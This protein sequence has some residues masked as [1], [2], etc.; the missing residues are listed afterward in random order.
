MRGE[1]GRPRHARSSSATV[2]WMP[3][4]PSTRPHELARALPHPRRRLLLDRRVRARAGAVRLRRRDRRARAE[5]RRVRAPRC[6]AWRA[7]PRGDGP[8]RGG[9]RGREAAIATARRLGRQDNVVLE[10]L[11][12]CRCARSS[13][14]EEARGR[15]EIVVDRLGPSDFN[16]PWMN[17]RADLI[18]ADLLGA[19]SASWSGSWPARVGRR[20]RGL[21]RGST[22]SITG[23]LA[24]Y[25]AEWEL[26]AGR[27]DDAVTWARRAIEL[28]R[29]GPPPQVRGDRAAVA[30]PGA[31]RAGAR[32][33]RRV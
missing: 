30:R 8:L 9:A 31:R 28:A 7:R 25:R 12:R 17:A 27:L 23:R 2:R 18:G 4:S 24:A 11:H 21:R 19:S 1:R 13:R 32:R 14:V 10:L 15:S 33:R 16:M 26:E 20:A 22:G 6:R 29:V 5:Q 3:G